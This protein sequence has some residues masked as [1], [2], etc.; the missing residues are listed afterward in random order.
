[1]KQTILVGGALAVG[2][3]IGIVGYYLIGTSGDMA[4]MKPAT[5]RSIGLHPWTRATVAMSPASSPM[6]WI[7]YPSHARRRGE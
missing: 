6:G 5:S 7:S 4:G 3:I 2:I 1:M